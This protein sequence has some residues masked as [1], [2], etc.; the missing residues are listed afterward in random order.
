ML[1]IATAAGLV[2][3]IKVLLVENV[4]A[5]GR[6]ILL[7]FDAPRELFESVCGGGILSQLLFLNSR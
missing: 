2:H 1:A 5:I 6:V 4:L 3:G 7:I